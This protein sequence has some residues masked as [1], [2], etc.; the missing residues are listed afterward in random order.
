V[1][2]T[3]ENRLR[4]L[5]V[6]AIETLRILTQCFDNGNKPIAK[7]IAVKLRVL[8]YDNGR[9]NRSLL[10]QLGIKN[11][12][13]YINT[14]QVLHPDNLLPSPGFV[15]YYIT[16]TNSQ[17]KAPLG[18]VP[19]PQQNSYLEFDNWWRDKVLK[20]IFGNILSREDMI[21]IL[22]NK[23]GGAH[24]HPQGVKAYIDI[25]ESN[26]LGLVSIGENGV[27]K[28]F[29]NAVIEESVRQIAYE[30]LRTIEVAHY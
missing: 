11:K 23:E 5:F 30:F 24:V 25:T 16:S 9:S 6:E 3:K 10:G 21:K 17:Y 28:S 1:D 27:K 14:A 18:D 15:E 12:L 22:A 26:S 7:E 19:P 13:Q 4:K 20:D 8:L 29:E 2:K